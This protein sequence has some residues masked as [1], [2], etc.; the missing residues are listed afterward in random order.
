MTDFESQATGLI[1]QMSQ[2]I[3]NAMEMQMHPD[4]KAY[5]NINI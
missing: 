3:N 1:N 2:E 5:N 4:I